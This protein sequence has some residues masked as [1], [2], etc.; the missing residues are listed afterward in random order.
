MQLP[1]LIYAKL[2]TR[3]FFCDK[4]ILSESKNELAL[5]FGG[6]SIQNTNICNAKCTFCG[7]TYDQSRPKHTMDDQ[8]YQLLINQLEELGGGDVLF[9]S[10][11][12]EPL[13]DK[14]F[15][16][17]VKKAKDNKFIKDIT[18]TTNGTLIRKHGAKN[19]LK[20][21]ISSITISTSAFDEDIYKSVYGLKYKGMYKS[22][23]G[24]LNEK[25]SD[26]QV[27][28]SFRSPLSSKNTQELKD[29]QAI[30]KKA[31]SINFLTRFDQF[32][33]LIKKSY[34]SGQMK[35]KSTP[36]IKNSACLFAIYNLAVYSN[37]DV[38][39]CGCRDLNLTEEM[40][41]GN[42]KDKTL[43]QMW[44]SKK[45]LDIIDSFEENRLTPI[46]QDCSWYTSWDLHV[47]NIYRKKKTPFSLKQR[48][49]VKA[50]KI[51][52]PRQPTSP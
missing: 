10:V 47:L 18:L 23:T 42:I 4:K 16:D 9:S 39:V 15:L 38:G 7:G 3:G 1:K 34:L 17:K 33:G 8:T 30:E 52:H 21:G 5:M 40:F 28:I 44:H 12:G 29:F 25:P 31:D 46:C 24:L 43:Y 41:L 32:G 19:I 13:V 50:H 45:R 20:S 26:V 22:V 14:H 48:E 37:G 6:I 11:Y 35:I 49:N 27:G 51:T 2:L 36:R